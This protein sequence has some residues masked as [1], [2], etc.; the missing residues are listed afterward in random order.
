MNFRFESRRE[1]WL[2]DC[3]E[4]VQGNPDQACFFRW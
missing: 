1:N 3:T 4:C 2:D